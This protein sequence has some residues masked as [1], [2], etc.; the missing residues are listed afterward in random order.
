MLR[1]AWSNLKMQFSN[2][3]NELQHASYFDENYINGKITMRYRNNRTP[4]RN[5]PIF[6]PEMWSVSSRTLTD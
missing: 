5:E 3:E 1:D 4:K 2:N 6:P